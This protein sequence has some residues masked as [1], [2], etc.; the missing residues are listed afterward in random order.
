[1]GDLISNKIYSKKE[2]RIIEKKQRKL[3]KKD[4]GRLFDEE[5]VIKYT[6]DIKMKPNELEKINN[7]I[8]INS[9]E[10]ERVNTRNTLRRLEKNDGNLLFGIAGVFIAIV[11]SFIM[12]LSSSLQ[13]E[14]SEIILNNNISQINSMLYKQVDMQ[15][16]TEEETVHIG[17]LKG[18]M[19]MVY[20]YIILL[21]I[22][23]IIILVWYFKTSKTKVFYDFKLICLEDYTRI[24]DEKIDILKE[25][26]PIKSVEMIEIVEDV[27]N[28][29]T[30]SNKSLLSII[31]LLFSIFP[32]RK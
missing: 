12:F 7:V 17:E 5:V 27:E 14:S 3:I 18:S 24:L 1:M 8:E 19:Y 10:E 21:V 28:N 2:F 4:S 31:M 22:F 13:G 9:L 29:N 16:Q 20:A 25:K 23:L 6:P 32:F 11:F 30:Y 15:R 26:N